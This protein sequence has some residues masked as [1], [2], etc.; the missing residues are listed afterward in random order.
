VAV[1]LDTAAHQHFMIGFYRTLWL[2]IAVGI[3]TIA[4]L[5]W[6]AARRGL[7]PVREMAKVAQRVTASRLDDRLPAATLPV[8]LLDLATAFNEML[9][10]LEDSF[11]RLSEFSSDIAHELRTPIASMMTQ[12]Q[13][14]LSRVRTADSYREVLY[15]NAEEFDRLARMIPT[16]SSS[17]RPTTA[18]RP[19]ASRRPRQRSARLE[20]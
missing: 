11:R 17:P 8:E 9:S 15:S 18:Y 16:C 12:T 3:V 5:G 7:A 6:V 19:A 4:L 20:F 1:A 10:R 14:A 2:A 13:V